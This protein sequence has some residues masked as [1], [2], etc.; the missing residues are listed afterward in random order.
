M[1][2]LFRDDGA[3]IGYPT[4]S[5]DLQTSA[6]PSTA[7]LHAHGQAAAHGPAPAA[8]LLEVLWRRRT[9]LIV[10]MLVCLV[11]AGGYILLSTRVYRASAKV[12]LQENDP[13]VF[14]EG[15]GSAGFSESYM[16]AQE[17][18]V[19]STSVLARAISAAGDRA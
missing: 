8:P 17:D 15:K 18:V 4:S 7:A 13:Q 1:P 9:T 19:L 16:Q 12:L 2:K 14:G 5:L 3:A 10:T 11:T 6:A